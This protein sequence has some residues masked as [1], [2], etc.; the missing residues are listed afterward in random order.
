MNPLLQALLALVIGGMAL[1]Y[2]MPL[3]LDAQIQPA[4][5]DAGNQVAQM[6]AA[7]AAYIRNHAAELLATSGGLAI[8]G[9][10][11]VTPAQLQTDG[12]LAWSFVDGNVFGQKHILVITQLPPPYAAGTLD[13]MVYTYGGDQ[14]SDP[15]AIRVAQAGPAGAT[16]VLA[17]DTA[18]FEGA[19]GGESV[20]VAYYQQGG[21]LTVTPGHI[22]AHILPAGYS[23]EAPF[24]NRYSTGNLDDNT[25]H[26]AQFMDGNNLEMAAPGAT[27]GGGNIDMAGGN[28]NA[29]TTMTATQKVTAPLLADPNGVNQ[30][31]PAGT[32]QIN[33]LNAS[34]NVTVTGTV[35]AS[36]YT[37]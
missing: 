12:D 11:A 3:L 8:G 15:V 16:V 30:V 9:T 7:G 22:G 28:V 32:S 26:T 2:G 33:T 31:T 34:G 35:Q 37:Y 21:A 1:N 14:I 27:V 6:Q 25:M 17:S 4:Q 23:A 24:L 36:I 19:A 10:L 18:N 29:A 5:N 13:G 20:P